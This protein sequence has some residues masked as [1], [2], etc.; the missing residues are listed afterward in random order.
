VEILG[1]GEVLSDQFRAHDLAVAHDQAA[2]G[3]MRKHDLADAGD[4]ERVDDAEQNREQ[5]VDSKS[6]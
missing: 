6:G 1:I 3:L 5:D 2:V 4:G